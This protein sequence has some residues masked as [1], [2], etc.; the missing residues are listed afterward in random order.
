[1]APS[2]AGKKQNNKM[3]LFIIFSLISLIVYFDT[4]DENNAGD[5]DYIDYIDNRESLYRPLAVRRN[6]AG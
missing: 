5:V 3:K 4:R 6:K 2:A 1:M